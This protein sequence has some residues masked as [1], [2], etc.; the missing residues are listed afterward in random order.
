MFMARPS[1]STAARASDLELSA[2]T[3]G[4]LRLSDALIERPELLVQETLGKGMS[5]C[6]LISE[7]ER[8]S[9]SCI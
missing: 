7:G 2:R 1:S 6:A 5:L 3:G 8:F 9:V 4:G